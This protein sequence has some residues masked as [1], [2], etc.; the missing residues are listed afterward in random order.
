MKQKERMTFYDVLDFLEILDERTK[1]TEQRL[2]K[3]EKKA[4]FE[5]E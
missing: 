3:V 2:R 1:D 4:L 5:V